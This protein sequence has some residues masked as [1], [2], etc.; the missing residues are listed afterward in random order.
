MRDTIFV[1][2]T[3]VFFVVSVLYV[4]FCDEVR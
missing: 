3:V 4:K 2:A 1:L